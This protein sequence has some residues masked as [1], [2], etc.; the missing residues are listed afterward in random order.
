MNLT[1]SIHDLWWNYCCHCLQMRTLDL[2]LFSCLQPCSIVGYENEF[3]NAR[4]ARSNMRKWFYLKK[5]ALQRQADLWG[6]YKEPF[7]SITAG[8]FIPILGYE[9]FLSQ[10]LWKNERKQ[11]ISNLDD[12]IH[13][14]HWFCNFFFQM[15]WNLNK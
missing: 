10:E 1:T 7:F 9:K 2:Y 6:A 11:N 8:R 4:I 12:F 14:A 3:M 15:I 5:S 13:L